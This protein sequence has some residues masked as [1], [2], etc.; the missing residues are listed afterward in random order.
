M[1]AYAEGYEL[2]A[3]EP[4]I[5]AV[6]SAVGA[7]HKD[8]W[9]LEVLVDA[10]RPDPESSSISAYAEDSGEAAAPSRIPTLTRCRSRLSR[11]PCLRDSPPDSWIRRR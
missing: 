1:Q 5:I 6:D 2:L 4:R 11:L 3:A 8:S 10:L 9:L 7:W